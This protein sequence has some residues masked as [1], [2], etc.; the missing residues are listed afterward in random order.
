M[1]KM[2]EIF[3]V[4]KGKDSQFAQKKKIFKHD[5]QKGLKNDFLMGLNSNKGKGLLMC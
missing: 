4:N 3:F 1:S 2:L 5:E